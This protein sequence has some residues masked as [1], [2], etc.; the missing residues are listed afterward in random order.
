MV[1]GSRLEMSSSRPLGEG[2]SSNEGI[3]PFVVVQ[4]NCRGWPEDVMLSL[5]RCRPEMSLVIRMRSKTE[6][7]ADGGGSERQL[8]DSRCNSDYGR[9]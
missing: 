2:A 1:I 9:W 4:S 7:V 6:A 8:G 5:P 3:L